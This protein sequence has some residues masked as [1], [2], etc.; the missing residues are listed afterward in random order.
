MK[1]ITDRHEIGKVLNF[2]KYPVL[3][4]NLENKPAASY[5]PDSDYAVGCKV[6]VAWDHNDPRYEGM[7]ENCTLFI[8]DGRYDLSGRWGCLHESFGR[9]DILEDAEWAMTQVVHKGQEVVLIEDWPSK[10]QCRVRMMKVSEHIDIHCQTVA[11]LI[12]AE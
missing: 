1:F 3:T 9:Q 8:E 6:R 10:G 2:G 7:T 4:I 11:Q 12:D 5:A